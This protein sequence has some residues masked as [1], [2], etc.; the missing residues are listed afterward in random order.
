MLSYSLTNTLNQL[1]MSDIN[2]ENMS[3]IEKRLLH[4]VSMLNMFGNLAEER[5][6]SS[7]VYREHAK[8]VEDGIKLIQFLKETHK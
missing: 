7:D 2:Y 8:N 1:A 4:T 3:T 6:E 5:G